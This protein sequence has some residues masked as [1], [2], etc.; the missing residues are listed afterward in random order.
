MFNKSITDQFK[1]SKQKLINTTPENLEQ[2]AGWAST[3]R[4]ST[5]R[6][7]LN[8]KLQIKKHQ[9]INKITQNKKKCIKLTSSKG[10][11]VNV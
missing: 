5:N 3:E 1:D 10:A 4:L 2:S 7:Q 6:N 11:A 8:D 9:E